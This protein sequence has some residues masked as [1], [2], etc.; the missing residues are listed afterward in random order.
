[1]FI[2]DPNFS[3]PDPKSRVKKIP[4]PGSG[5]ALKNLNTGIFNPKIVSKL[6]E[7]V[8]RMFILI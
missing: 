7:I 5:S 6:W 1:M 8:S 2:P 3:I 4:N